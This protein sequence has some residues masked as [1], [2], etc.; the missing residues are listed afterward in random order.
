VT[1]EIAIEMVT[2][3]DDELVDAFDRLIPQLSTS[4][5]PPGRDGLSTIVG[6]TNCV[7]FLA[8]LG[9]DIV[10]ALTLALYP[11]PTGLKAWIDDVVVDAAARGRGVG[12]ALSVAA[13]D[14]AQR[15]GAKEVDLT[16]RPEREAA[17]RLYQRLGFVQRDTNVYRYTL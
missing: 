14:E 15:R 3:V 9:S 11:L 16:S 12:E 17:N 5:P 13:L 10:G 4:A 8:R 6:N 1:G 2:A 7:L